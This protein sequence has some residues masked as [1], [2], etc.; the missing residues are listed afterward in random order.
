MHALTRVSAAVAFVSLLACMHP[1]AQKFTDAYDQLIV[2]DGE[3]ALAELGLEFHV[4]KKTVRD[5]LGTPHNI[6]NSDYES[7]RWMYCSV[8]TWYHGKAVILTFCGDELWGIAMS[9]NHSM[10][11]GTIPDSTFRREGEYEDAAD[12]CR[13]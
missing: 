2:D 1:N 7:T 11:L 3:A 13:E 10:C 4:S 12:V 5:K 6:L 9:I 8:N